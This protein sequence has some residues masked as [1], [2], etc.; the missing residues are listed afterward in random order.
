MSCSCHG[1]GLVTWCFCVLQTWSFA[2]LLFCDL[3][4]STL[5]DYLVYLNPQFLAVFS[6]MC[7]L[8]CACLSLFCLSFT[9]VLQIFCLVDNYLSWLWDSVVLF[10]FWQI[11]WTFY[12]LPIKSCTVW[13]CNCSMLQYMC[14]QVTNAVWLPFGSG[15]VARLLRGVR[16]NLL[17][18]LIVLLEF[19]INK[20]IIK[21]LF[22]WLM[23]SIILNNIAKLINFKYFL[24]YTFHYK[25]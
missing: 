1:P 14:E 17:S 13:L 4:F 25:T 10:C 11:I 9:F 19:I 22:N 8:S 24:G 16:A 20:V 6:S 12:Y 5:P 3:W 18:R 7:P 2:A 23:L 15:Q 21:Q